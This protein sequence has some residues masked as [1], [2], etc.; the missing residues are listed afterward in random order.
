M[1]FGL[2]KCVVLEMRRGR[3]V[4]SSGIDLTDD[5]HIGETGRR[6]QIFWHLTVGPG[7]QH[8]DESQNNIGTYQK[9]QEVV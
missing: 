2:E 4:D 9:R 6:L 1:S 7:P 8:S 3:Q 5:Q